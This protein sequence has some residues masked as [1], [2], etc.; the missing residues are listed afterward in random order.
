MEDLT[1][2][3]RIE[4][5]LQ[6]L[7]AA[8]L[9]T[10]VFEASLRDDA[11][12]EKLLMAAA[13]AGSKDL[14]SLRKVAKQATRTPGFVDWREAG[15]YANRL[16]NL[17]VLLEVRI[18]EGVPGLVQLI[19]EAISLAES[20]L[21]HIDDSGGEVMPAILHLRKV[22]QAACTSLRPEPVALA[23]RLHDYQMH[24]EWDTYSDVL[25]DY[26]KALGEA[27][28]KVYRTRVE[29][30]WQ[31][32]PQLNPEDHRDGWSTVRYRVEAAMEAIAT[33]IGD[34][35]LLFAVRTKNLSS[36]ARF[37]ELARMFQVRDRVDEALVWVEQGIAA[38]PHE[39]LD[40]L[41]SFGIELQLARGNHA[42]VEHLA[43][44][45]FEK[46][47]GREAYFRLLEV[48]DWIDRRPVLRE[49]ALTYLWGRVAEDESPEGWPG[50]AAGSNLCAAK[51]SP[52]SCARV[53]RRS[54]GRRSV[55]GALSSGCGTESLP[56]VARPTM[57]RRLRSTSD[58]C[59]M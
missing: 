6:A 21:Q 4:G 23:K 49:E 39:R 42:E 20:A 31:V 40:D 26:A 11:L 55:V 28:L 7:D 35:E 41:L 46:S 17:A 3:E 44:Q 29:D 24:G 34:F 32:L 38:V 36:P 22:H 2:D 30:A 8:A 27:G 5:Y 48:A 45:R 9:R 56:N 52:P 50:A 19:E 25:P 16:D 10:L 53:T 51:S 43:W 47:A 1:D 59:R 37:L 18:A 33:H 54:C 12:R 58:C 13:V 57:R 14:K 15:D